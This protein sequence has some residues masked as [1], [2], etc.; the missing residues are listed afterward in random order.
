MIALPLGL[1]CL[2]RASGAQ[3]FANRT[4]VAVP[5]DDSLRKPGFLSGFDLLGGAQHSWRSAGNDRAWDI[6]LVNDAEIWRFNRKTTIVVGTATEVVAN[7]LKDG[8]FNPRGVSWELGVGIHRR[9]ASSIAQLSF[10]H[11]CRHAIDSADPPGPEYSIPGYVPQQRTASFNGFRTSL[12]SPPIQLADRLWVRAGIA[13]E[14]YRDQWDS[15]VVA[16]DPDSWRHARGASLAAIR[17]EA[18]LTASQ[19][20]FVRGTSTGVLFQTS[21]VR[22]NVRA[23]R[24]TH[25]VEGGLRAYGHTAAM[26]FYVVSE[27]LFDDLMTPNPRGSHVLGFGIRAVGLNGF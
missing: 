24:E 6:H 21:G 25:R 1:M 27:S 3:L 8:G 18:P 14:V 5:L 15:Q 7:N 9:I 26:E 19:S 20:L 11:Y 4:L 22:P 16:T 13:G 23:L 10:V 17:L 12:S 2:P